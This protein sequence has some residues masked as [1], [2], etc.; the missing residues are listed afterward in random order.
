MLCCAAN[1][2]CF[3]SWCE[4]D[5]SV[6]VV[7]VMLKRSAERSSMSALPEGDLGEADSQETV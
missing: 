5:A 2:L 6:Q 3:R 7:A 4:A 1:L